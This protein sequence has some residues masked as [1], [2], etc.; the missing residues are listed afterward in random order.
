MAWRVVLAG[1]SLRG[2]LHDG[3]EPAGGAGRA[4]DGPPGSSPRGHGSCTPCWGE[5]VPTHPELF[6]GKPEATAMTRRTILILAGLLLMGVGILGLVY[7]RVSYQDEEV[8]MELGSMEASVATEEHVT[9]P[10]IVSGLVLL[11]GVGVAAVGV[12]RG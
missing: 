8:A 7:Q 1:P 4:E 12:T 10:P 9:I 11:A 3:S 2:V 5:G 6:P